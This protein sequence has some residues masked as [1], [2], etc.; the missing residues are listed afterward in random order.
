M[1]DSTNQRVTNKAILKNYRFSNNKL[2]QKTESKTKDVI[3]YYGE[4]VGFEKYQFIDFVKKES[5]VVERSSFVSFVTMVDDI[6]ARSALYY[7]TSGMYFLSNSRPDFFMN[8]YYNSNKGSF[9][10]YVDKNVYTV[11]YSNDQMNSILQISFD[12]NM[13]IA[14]K[15]ELIPNQNTNNIESSCFEIV[16]SDYDGYIKKQYLK[17]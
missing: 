13:K 11:V 3:D 2:N 14:Y 4:L 8:Y 10:F 6:N 17:Q 1:A 9:F 12:D 16:I 7:R 15:K 5:Q